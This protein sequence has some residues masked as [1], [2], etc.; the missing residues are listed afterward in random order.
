[1]AASSILCYH[2]VSETWGASLTVTPGALERQADA[3]RRRGYVGL[4]ATEAERRR[5]AGTLPRRSVVFTFD[6]AFASMLT[7][8]PIL[9]TA[10]FPATVFVPTGFV[11]A[12]SPLEW[13]GTG[14][15][16]TTPFAHELEPATWDDLRRLAEAGWEIGS[17]TVSHP[18]LPSLDD[19]GLE[20]ELNISKATVTR[21]IGSCTS[22][23][24][25][26]GDADERVATATKAA[27]Y[28]AAVVLPPMRLPD[29][30]LSRPRVGI[31]RKDQGWRERLKLSPAFGRFQQAQIQAE[32]LKARRKAKAA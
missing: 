30:P 10:G 21:E 20:N 23:A 19:A 15:W 14:Q 12:G 28:E 22:I 5:Q 17:H 25:P 3:L 1:M 18:R 7:A 31:Y 11:D 32:Q 4:T 6:D 9:R 29:A 2:A 13:P 27:G 26:Y 8:L 16:L 24:Y